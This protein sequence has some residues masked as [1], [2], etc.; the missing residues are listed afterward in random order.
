MSSVRA[1]PRPA[2]RPTDRTPLEIGRRWTSEFVER[3]DT[4]AGTYEQLNSPIKAEMELR[5]QHAL[6]SPLKYRFSAARIAEA[7][8]AVRNIQKGKP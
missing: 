1:V 3:R 6:L 5:V 2:P 8:H 7:Q 4:L